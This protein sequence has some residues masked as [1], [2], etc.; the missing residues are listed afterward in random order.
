[1]NQSVIKKLHVHE[2]LNIR[3]IAIIIK[4]FDITPLKCRYRLRFY[5]WVRQIKIY[6]KD[7]LINHK[8][9]C[10]RNG[11]FYQG[12][13]SQVPID[14]GKYLYVHT[15]DGRSFIDRPN[16]GIINHSSLGLKAPSPIISAG[17][18]IF[19][20]AKIC[21]IN[22]DSGHYRPKNRSYLFEKALRHIGASFH[23]H[24]IHIIRKQWSFLTRVRHQ[25]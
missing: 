1:M 23:P 3:D 6:D 7:E 21:E 4:M 19:E 18:I 25:G 15:C 22:E 14:N 12:S 10:V 2:V 5:D 16:T 20:N 24:Y 8:L 11:R 17:E 13:E 9:L